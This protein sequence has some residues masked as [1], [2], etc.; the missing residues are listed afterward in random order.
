MSLLSR[1]VYTKGDDDDVA[2]IVASIGSTEFGCSECGGDDT[3]TETETDD[4]CDGG[5]DD[6]GV[7]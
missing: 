5:S 3:D 7:I 2:S 1:S 4:D 6:D